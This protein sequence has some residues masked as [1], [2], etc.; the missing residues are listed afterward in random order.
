MSVFSV[1]FL[2]SKVQY[3]CV[4]HA[5]EVQVLHGRIFAINWV[6]QSSVLE[7]NKLG[8]SVQVVPWRRIRLQFF[9]GKG[10]CLLSELVLVRSLL[11]GGSCMHLRDLLGRFE[12][13]SQVLRGLGAAKPLSELV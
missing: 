12:G 2:F 4:F 5:A 8:T 7:G 3:L 13:T 11:R 6:S 1:N 10:F 9:K